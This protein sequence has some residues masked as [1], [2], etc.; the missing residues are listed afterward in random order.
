MQGPHRIGSGRSGRSCN[1]Q[2]SYSPTGSGGL[3]R[4]MFSVMQCNEPEG[5]P[6]PYAVHTWT[7]S[8][9]NE[10]LKSGYGRTVCTACNGARG[11]VYSFHMCDNIVVPSLIS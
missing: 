9:V 11:E 3:T 8:S 7:V 4:A 1:G 6:Y 5:K 10:R 2:R